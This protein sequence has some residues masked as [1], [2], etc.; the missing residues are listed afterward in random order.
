MPATAVP[1]FSARTF[2]SDAAQLMMDC[3]GGTPAGW[4]ISNSPGRSDYVGMC[5]PRRMSKI[6]FDWKLFYK[7]LSVT[8]KLASVRQVAGHRALATSPIARSVRNPARSVSLLVA[9]SLMN[10]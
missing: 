8:F 5:L 3:A 2:A 6:S 10:I 9:V 1:R 7:S 4:S